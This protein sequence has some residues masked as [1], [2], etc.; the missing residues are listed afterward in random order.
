[1]RD[2]RDEG[3]TGGGAGPDTGAGLGG[4]GIAFS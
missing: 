1:M 2:M 3:G 4:R